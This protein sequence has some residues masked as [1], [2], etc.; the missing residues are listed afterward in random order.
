MTGRAP[1]PLL[2]LGAGAC[3]LAFCTDHPL[4][5]AALLIAAVELHRAAPQAGRFVLVMAAT[6]GLGVALLNPFVQASGELILLEL[7][8]VPIFDTQVTL[9]ELVAGLTLGARAAAVTIIV[10]AV[11][12]LADPDRLL[13]LASRLLPRSALA[14]SIAA[15]LVPTFRRDAQSLVETARLRGRSPHSGS[16]TRRAQ[17]AGMLALPLVGSALDRSIDVAEAM[18]ARGYGAGPRTRRP[19]P[20]LRRS[21]HVLVAVGVALL[22]L[23][24]GAAFGAIGA[25]DFFPTMTA[26]TAADAAVAVACLAL[27]AAA[28]V[29]VR[30]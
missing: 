6:L 7:P 25:F 11:I 15:R 8:R 4:V 17:A 2:V 26:P 9:E 29:A 10:M 13:E 12:A 24:V 3:T 27:G 19:G 28:G 1:G 16:F 5:I 23:G 20:P 21:D 22:G 30:R 14:A 18:A